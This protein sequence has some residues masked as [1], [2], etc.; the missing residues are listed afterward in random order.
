MEDIVKVIEYLGIKCMV[1]TR[2]NINYYNVS[3][4]TR[5]I[6]KPRRNYSRWIKTKNAQEQINEAKEESGLDDVTIDKTMLN[7]E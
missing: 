4:W 6:K 5:Q 1:I 3:D 7:N 2:N